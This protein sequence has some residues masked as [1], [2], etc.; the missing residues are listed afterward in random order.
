[1]KSR[2]AIIDEGVGIPKE[3]QPFIFDRYFR[4]SNVLTSQGTG[5]GLNIVRQHMLNLG[6]DIH[7]KS[8]LDKGSTFTLNIP[9]KYN[10]DEKNSIG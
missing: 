9:I 8:K 1:M 2:I 3:D 6:G 10:E 7:F 5:I 4:A